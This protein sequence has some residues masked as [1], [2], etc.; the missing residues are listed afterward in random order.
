MFDKRPVDMLINAIAFANDLS[1]AATIDGNHLLIKNLNL[2]TMI[3]D[4]KPNEV[5]VPIVNGKVS[6]KAV[7]RALKEMGAYLA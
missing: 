7:E 2:E 5:R 3:D 4:S 6:S 1:A